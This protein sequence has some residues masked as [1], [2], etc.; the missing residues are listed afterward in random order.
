[1]LVT[2]WDKASKRHI[3]FN[4]DGTAARDLGD[5]DIWEDE[6]A[7]RRIAAQNSAIVVRC[8][9]VREAHSASGDNPSATICFVF[10]LTSSDV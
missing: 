9:G 5:A 7:A 8:A 6:S 10:E 1:M 3:Y 4:R 2:R